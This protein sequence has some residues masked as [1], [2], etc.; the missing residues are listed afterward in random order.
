[1]TKSKKTS[2]KQEVVTKKPV[3]AIPT[4]PTFNFKKPMFDRK[5]QNF[6]MSFRTQNRGAK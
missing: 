2:P 4:K 5:G 6:K 1:M 3:I